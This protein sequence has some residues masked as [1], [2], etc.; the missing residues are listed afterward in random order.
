MKTGDGNGSTWKNLSNMTKGFYSYEVVIY[1]GLNIAKVSW[2]DFF[3]DLVDI[4]HL[5]ENGAL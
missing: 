5:S 4:M 1:R 2:K 3:C